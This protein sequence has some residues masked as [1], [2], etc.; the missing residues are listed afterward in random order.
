MS[1]SWNTAVDHARADWRRMHPRKPWP[2]APDVR[3]YDLR[4]SYGTAVYRAT[5]DIRAAQ[6]LL[7]NKTLAV[8]MRYTL[9]AVDA[10]AQA[11]SDALE[12]AQPSATTVPRR[13]GKGGAES[14]ANG[15]E[16][17]TGDGRPDEATI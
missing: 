16:G 8:T 5:N 3:P 7:R 9:A 1:K 15:V 17:A 10:Q 12:R 6:N 11:A 14:D 13:R 2:L 4:H